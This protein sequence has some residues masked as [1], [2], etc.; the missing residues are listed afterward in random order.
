MN[1]RSIDLNLLVILEALLEER[2]VSRAAAR[3][4]LSQPAASN[5][6]DRCRALFA[7]P[8]L[9]RRGRTMQLS[10]RAE[11]LRKPL[12]EI[13]RQAERLLAPQVQTPLA[14]VQRTVRILASDALVEWLAPVLADALARE[15]PG[16][17]T[18]FR[19]ARLGTSTP[20]AL[21]KG[22]ADLAIG[23]VDPPDEPEIAASELGEQPMAVLM[24]RGHSLESG[25]TLEEWLAH[26]HVVVSVS[27]SAETDLDRQLADLGLRRQVRLVVPGFGPAL[28]ALGQ[29]DMLALMPAR[30]ASERPN[31]IAV[32]APLA[33][34]PLRLRL[35]RRRRWLD[36]PALNL[37]SERIAQALL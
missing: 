16:I 35:Y 26:P 32:E 10:P 14:E 11:A 24:R 6:L 2:S 4:G 1:L 22:E 36:D 19:P 17:L 13:L 5:A 29:S 34:P 21:L 18:V 8:L 12:G 7:D 25:L 3:I 37:V 30:L 20:E 27:G 23:V 15:A 9:E 28:A 33:Q 31:L